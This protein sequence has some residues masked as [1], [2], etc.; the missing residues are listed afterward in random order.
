MRQITPMDVAFLYLENKNT[1]AHGTL[2]WLYDASDCDPGQIDR[3]AL[4]EHMRERVHVSPV[5]TQKLHRLPLEF[6]YPYWVDDS[7]F[8]LLY[9]V[10]ESSDPSP[11]NWQ[12]LCEMIAA[13]HSTPLDPA[14]PLW[15]MMLVS[16]L[17]DFAGLPP[18][19]FAIIAKFHH[20]AIDGAT[21]M[22]IIRNIHSHEGDAEV[23][24]ISKVQSADKPTLMSSLFRAA[25]RNLGATDKLLNTLRHKKQAATPSKESPASREHTENQA[26][27]TAVPQTLFN[28]QVSTSHVFDNRIFDLAAIKQLRNAVDGATVNDVLLCICAGGLRHFLQDQNALPESTMKAGCPINI[29]TEGEASSG[30][31][32]ISAMI[33]DLHTDVADPVQ[34]LQA[35][36]QSSSS[37]K[38]A[39]AAQGSRKIVDIVELIP[40]AGQAMLGRVVGK[41]SGMLNRAVMFNCPISNLPGPQEPLSILGGRLVNIAAAMPVMPGFGLFIG[42]CTC[43]GNLSISMTSSANIMPHPQELGDCMELA[44]KELS[45]AAK[46]KRKKH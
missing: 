43:A 19:C 20:V 18:R 6:D 29:R 24:H 36:T 15:Q 38:L 42:L 9:H 44:Y 14:H 31:N 25:V 27:K 46:R 16:E 45:V 34:R 28:Q 11:E 7:S 35:I 12:Q 37:A 26:A 30:G 22:A 4:V 41:V 17:N 21:G 10:R 3:R 33:V 2:V 39:V 40:A 5:F 1:H 13:Y 32:M 8:E 23:H